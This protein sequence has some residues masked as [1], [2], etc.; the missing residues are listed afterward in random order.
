[1]QSLALADR[2]TLSDHDGPGDEVRC[3]GVDGPNLCAAAIAAFRAATGWD[4]PPQLLE[5]AKHVPVAA[6]MG[7]G[8][9]DAAAA[10]RLLAARSGIADPALELELA[11]ALGADVPGQLRPGRVLA[12]GAGEHVVRL[13]DPDPFGVLVLPSRERLS[14]AAVYA[15]ADRMGLPRDAAGLA[16][17]DPLARPEYVNE[18]E[19]AARALVPAIDRALA[20]A[21]RLGAHTAMVS[22]S[23]PTVVGLFETPGA[24][25]RAARA[26]AGCDP[27]ALASIPFIPGVRHNPGRGS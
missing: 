17:V 22:G 8:S 5:I 27:P 4:G 13:P 19:P 9:G 2:V 18:L 24:A 11:T 23:G 12:T 20:L 15:E 7:G 10:L 26:A 25:R 3:P 14:T 21:R 6:G 1:M 16:A